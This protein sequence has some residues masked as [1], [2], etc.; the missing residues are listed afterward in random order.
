MNGGCTCG[1]D[2]GKETTDVGTASSLTSVAVGSVSVLLTAAVS[3][4]ASFTAASLLGIVLVCVE[5]ASIRP[6]PNRFSQPIVAL[7]ISCSQLPDGKRS[8]Q[9]ACRGPRERRCSHRIQ[10]RSS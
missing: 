8:H 5:Q 7:F 10:N 6:A 3:G 2:G 4:A 9:T 1:P